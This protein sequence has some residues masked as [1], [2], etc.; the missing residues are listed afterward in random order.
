MEIIWYHPSQDATRWIHGLQ[1]RLPHVR[2]RGWQPGD[3]A[4]ADYALVRSP[5]V[6]MLRGRQG[7]R[8]VFALGGGVDEILAQLKHHPDMLPDTVP[9]FR[10]EDTG[11]ARQMQEYATHSVLDW[12]RRFDDYRL[13]QPQSCWQ[14]L[15]SYQRETFTI[16][17]LGAGVLGQRVADSLKIWGFPLR[18][19]SRSPKQL[20][21]ITSFAGRESLNDFLRGTQ[22]LINLLPNTPET[23]NLINRDVLQRLPQGAFF[24]NLARGAQVVEADL[25]AALNSGQLKAAALDVFQQEPL[26]KNHP[27]WSHPRVTI[28]RH[29]A[30]ITVPEEAMDYIARAITQYEAGKTPQGCVDRQRGY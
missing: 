3:N 2:V 24:L 19:W 10:L 12:F 23:L 6:E 7:L 26:P 15:P 5:P 11:M 30:A 27:L 29:N 18:V 8:G 28:T 21:G 22:V 1:Q 13:Q 17:I 25:L 20:E 9:L 14:Q 16:G 4:P